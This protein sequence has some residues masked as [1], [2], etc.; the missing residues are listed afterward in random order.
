MCSSANNM[1]QNVLI[2][3][4]EHVYP[5]NNIKI[6]KLNKDPEEMLQA[7]CIRNSFT[8]APFSTISISLFSPRFLAVTSERASSH[9]GRFHRD[10]F[11]P[12][13]SGTRANRKV[14]C[15]QIM[16]IWSE[17]RLIYIQTPPLMSGKCLHL[18][19]EGTERRK[20]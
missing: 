16:Q 20:S 2:T 17:L 6:P 9:Q 3:F 15:Q 7:H 5:Q 4:G 18:P 10:S 11:C 12:N 8:R 14:P 13:P 1:M 19:K